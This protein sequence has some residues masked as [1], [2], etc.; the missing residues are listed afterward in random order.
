VK[1]P[2]DELLHADELYLV[3]KERVGEFFKFETDIVYIEKPESE[4][5]GF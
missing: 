4:E 1:V 2:E 5:T 3:L